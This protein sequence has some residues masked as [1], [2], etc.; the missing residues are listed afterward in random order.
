MC[1]RFSL[2]FLLSTLFVSACVTHTERFRYAPSTP[3]YAPQDKGVWAE[4]RRELGWDIPSHQEPFYTRTVRGVKEAVSG[5]FGGKDPQV[6]TGPEELE[7]SRRQFEQQR[8][9]AFR[10]LRALQEQ[11]SNQ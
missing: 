5:W 2:L 4:L 11:E 6:N 3:Y 10:R 7:Q 8:A 9:A 1:K